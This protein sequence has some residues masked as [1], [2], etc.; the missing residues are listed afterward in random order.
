[1]VVK[2]TV[3]WEKLGKKSLIYARDFRRVS[4]IVLVCPGCCNKI[5]QTEWLKLQEF[6]SYSLEAAKSKVKVLANR[7]PQQGPFSWLV[8][9]RL[10][11]VSLHGRGLGSTLVS[12]LLSKKTLI[13]LWELHPQD[14]I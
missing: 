9:G 5:P 14:F 8:D 10:P 2:N 12:R 11:D 1:M 3:L 4:Q 7:I 6:I 13:P